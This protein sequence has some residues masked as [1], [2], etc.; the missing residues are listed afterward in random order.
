MSQDESRSTVSRLL[1]YLPARRTW[2]GAGRGAFSA[3]TVVSYL[4]L[5]PDGPARSGTAPVGRLPKARSVDLVFDCL[6]V[7]S[8]TIDA[9]RLNE[10]KLRLAL[11]NLLE[12]RMLVDS[13]DCHFAS[14]PARTGAGEP[15]TGALAGS[16]R[17]SVAAI[18][19][20]TLSRTLELFAQSQIYPQAAYSEIYTVP[21][22]REG[23]FCLRVAGGRAMLRTG[24]DQACVF[25][26]DS[27]AEGALALAA[28]QMTIARL[29]IYGDGDGGAEL[30]NLCR[31]L[32][33][34]GEDAGAP[35]DL[36]AL[37]DAVNLLQG[38]YAPSGG[39]GGTGRWLARQL[40]DGA[41]RAPAIWAGICA[42]IAI[43]GLNAYWIKL[44]TQY[45]DLRLS[46]RHAFHDAF[47]NES[48]IVDEL[49]QAQRSV[50][51]LR[52]RAGRASADDFTVLN[53]QALRIFASAP[54][55]IV[56]AVEYADR[57]LRIRLKPG[58][59]DDAGMRNGLQAKALAQ[60]LA[61]RFESDGL[62]VQL[63]PVR[64]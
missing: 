32:G 18:D 48:T 11:P 55:G 56:S 43:G 44:D 31:G 7:Y 38:P 4:A 24:L 20:G 1:V 5:P 17:L 21:R 14:A 60:G 3:A 9:P 40:R 41:W 6:D 64:E 23:T 30:Q 22:P 15:Q 13:A 29:R 25:D 42:A 47:P 34:H 35:A 33:L 16:A 37:A 19:H 26:L 54:V 2:P 12:E 27:G 52:A 50:A 57:I 58:S 51:G 61:L 62:A 49:A 8:A 39:L 36:Q 10:A 45:R 53:A 46:M 59:M 63:S 28:R